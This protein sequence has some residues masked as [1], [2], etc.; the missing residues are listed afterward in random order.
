MKRYLQSFI[1]LLFPKACVGCNTPLLREEPFLCTR[2]ELEL[3]INPEI[4]QLKNEV[5]DVFSGRLPL[6]WAN[7]FLHFSK[8]GITQSLIHALKYKDREDLG[9]ELGLRFGTHIKS[10]IPEIPDLIIPVPLHPKKQKSR[11]YNQCQSIA[12]GLAQALGTKVENRVISRT[13][14]NRSQT[15]LNRAK[16]WK[17]VQGIFSLSNPDSVVQNHILLIDDTLT[18]GATLESCGLEL[19]KAEGVKLS[20]A[21]LAYAK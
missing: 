7:A 21:T 11:G 5:K 15:R 20:I 8:N 18:T 10:I 13:V 2:C 1:D 16:R 17:N 19:L 14:S 3:P 4:N 9:Y 6:L 12:A